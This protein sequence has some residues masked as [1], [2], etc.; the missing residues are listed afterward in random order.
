MNADRG[1]R[2]IVEDTLKKK[3]VKVLWTV[4]Y[5]QALPLTPQAFSLEGVLPA[6]FYMFRWGQRRGKGKFYDKVKPG[7]PKK[8][9]TIEDV[10]EKLTKG[11]DGVKGFSG[12]AEQGILGDLLLCFCLENKLH[13]PGRNE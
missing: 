3:V 12:Q 5:F 2:E 9:P 8:G 11:L 6:V 4:N 1:I 13:K 10:S 7:D